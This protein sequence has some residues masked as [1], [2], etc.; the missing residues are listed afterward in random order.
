M[1]VLPNI[2]VLSPSDSIEAY[3][4]M[5]QV[6][7][8]KGPV[9]LRLAREKSP[10]L[11]EKNYTPKIGKSEI[12]YVSKNT[13]PQKIGIIATGP[14]LYEALLA[15]EELHTANIQVS[16]L[17]VHTI[18][19]VD[20]MQIVKFATSFPNII[21]VEEGQAA[22]GLGG[23][24]AEI[25]AQHKPTRMIMLGS[26]DRYGQSGTVAELYREYGIDS[27]SIVRTALEHINTYF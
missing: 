24:V 8:I 11:Y 10:L 27:A 17:N 25:L 1:R 23:I 20:P 15:A 26:Q 4:L 13:S 18:K 2:T 3:E 22:G 16:V 21:T 14:I 19:P 7:Y 9:Y 5:K 6:I 12:V